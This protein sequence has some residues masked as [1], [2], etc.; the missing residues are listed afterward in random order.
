MKGADPTD[1]SC[2]GCD[3]VIEHGDG[4]AVQVVGDN[5][6]GEPE[7]LSPADRRVYCLDCADLD[8]EGSR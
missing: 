1:L 4:L 8:E 3:A 5:D 7:T 6:H 2:D